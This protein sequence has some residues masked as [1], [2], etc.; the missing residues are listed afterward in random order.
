MNR[1]PNWLIMRMGGFVG[2]GLKKNA[3][4]D[5]LTGAPVWLDP[6]SELQFIGTDAA[7][8][9]V[10]GLAFKGV[11]R[12]IVNLGATGLVNIGALHR[13]I[14]SKSVFQPSAPIVRF[15]LSLDKLAALTGET[16]PNAATEVET[17]VAGELSRRKMLPDAG[18]VRV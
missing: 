3:V 17:F 2:P 9:L 13:R 15:E 14:G 18:T 5:M 12:E 16:L 4:F 7:A 6:G 1:H 8:Q 10:I 11:R